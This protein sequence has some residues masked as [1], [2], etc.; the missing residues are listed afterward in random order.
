MT[1]VLKCKILLVVLIFI[2]AG[3]AGKPKP[4]SIPGYDERG[5]RLIVVMPVKAPTADPELARLMR[6][7]VAE[8]LYFKGYPLIPLQV[9]D[10][11]LGK[12]YNKQVDLSAAIPPQAIRSLLSADAVLYVELHECR[13][14]QTYLYASTNISASFELRDAK[15]GEVIWDAKR[16]NV[17]R[18][19][20]ITKQRLRMSVSQIVEPALQQIVER[21]LQTL[22]DGPDAVK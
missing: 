8:T 15:T 5:I 4:V 14:T 17:V 11:Q 9:I 20:D 19:F 6:L 1:R 7:K 16:R 13:T 2:V 22:P 10:E 18:N 3:C 21:A 12:A